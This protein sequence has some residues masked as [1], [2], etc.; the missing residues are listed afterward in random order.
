MYNTEA[1][2]ALSMNISVKQ[3]RWLAF[4]PFT[5]P[6]IHYSR[7]QIAKKTGETRTIYAPKPY[8]KT[9]QI[10]ILKNILDNLAVHDAAHGF[11]RHRSIITNAQPH[12]GADIIIKLDLE[13]FFSSITY[14]HVQKLFLSL[15][16]SQSIGT[17]LSLICTIKDVETCHPRCLPSGSPASPTI[18][19]LVCYNLDQNLSQIASD[20]GFTYTRYADDLTFSGKRDRANISTLIKQLLAVIAQFGFKINPNKIQI[21]PKSVRQEVTGIVVNHKLNISQTKLKAFRA[22]LHQIEQDGLSGKKWG[23]SPNLIA[24]I[25]GFSNYVAMIN[26]EKGGELL[27]SVERIKQKHILNTPVL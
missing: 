25:T 16:Y 17:L 2:L 20:L 6:V 3:L 9:A 12:V 19:N 24:S 18:S 27:E 23:N 10:Y 26:P 5:Y 21:L 15:G 1:E 8:L 14:K 11:R 22:T 13:N 4:K 7:F